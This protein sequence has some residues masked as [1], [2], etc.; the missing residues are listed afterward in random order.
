MSS[1]LKRALIAA[2]SAALVA[3]SAGAQLL[4][5]LGVPSL[6]PVGLPTRNV[7]V[8]GP[9]LDN[10]LA[11]PAGREAVAP[12]LNTV[13]GL[14]QR[15]IE[16]GP[17][18]LLELRKLRLRELIR[19]YPRELESDGDGLP[20]RR[21]VLVTID[22][23]PRS[24]ALASRAGFRIVDDRREAE[25]KSLA[26]CRRGSGSGTKPG[27]STQSCK[28]SLAIRRSR[29]GRSLPSPRMWRRRRRVRRT[30]AKARMRVAKSFS[31]E[32]R[33]MAMMRSLARG[34]GAASASRR[35]ALSTALVP[36][37]TARAGDTPKRAISSSR[38]AGPGLTTRSASG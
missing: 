26:C 18:T 2:T 35:A 3:G 5:S 15:V 12:T 20:V 9:V 30:M 1:F 36:R 22:P 24:L 14:P 7:P 4:P 19:Q 6:P 21:G 38:T 33:P 37:L 32:R 10:I 31:G 23:E 28:A 11:T 34:M 13:S 27:R 25:T 17:S 16:A 8:V 29:A